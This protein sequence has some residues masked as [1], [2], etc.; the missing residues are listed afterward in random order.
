MGIGGD[1]NPRVWILGPRSPFASELE[2]RLRILSIPAGRKQTSLHLLDLPGR[3]YTTLTSKKRRVI[4]RP[5]L[6]QVQ[7]AQAY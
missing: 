3:A 6:F 7:E 4:P 2:V 1:A 5:F